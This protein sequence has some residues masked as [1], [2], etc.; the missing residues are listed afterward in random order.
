MRSGKSRFRSEAKLGG[1]QAEIHRDNTSFEMIFHFT[2]LLAIFF[3]HNAW[4]GTTH[5]PSLTDTESHGVALKRTARAP[6]A[7]APYKRNPRGRIVASVHRKSAASS[8]EAK[9]GCVLPRIFDER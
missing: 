2:A 3:Y 5:L 9:D 6:E 7:L 4:R 1:R 8:A